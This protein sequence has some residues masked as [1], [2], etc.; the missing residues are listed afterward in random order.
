MYK[1]KAVLSVGA[2]SYLGKRVHILP[3]CL[4]LPTI[5]YGV[6]PKFM[7]LVWLAVRVCPIGI[8]CAYI[9]LL[10][11]VVILVLVYLVTCRL[12]VLLSALSLWF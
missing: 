1:A 6:R 7:F 2:S 11:L 12:S 3:E 5:F 8:G 9:L 10:L 4:Y